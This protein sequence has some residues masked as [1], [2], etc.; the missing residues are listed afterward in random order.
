MNK[1]SLLHAHQMFE[2][3][4][5][6]T[7]TGIALVYGSEQ[8]SYQE[9]NVQANQLAHYLQRLGVGPESLV[10]VCME[11]SFEAVIG[12]LAILKAG[13][14]Y[15]SLD[16]ATPPERLAFMLEDT[17][18][19]LLLTK[20]GSLDPHLAYHGQVISLDREHPFYDQESPLNPTSSVSAQ[21]QAYVIYT[22]GSTGQPKGV[23]ITHRGLAN[24]IRWHQQAFHITP[25]DRATQVAS[26]SFD[27]SVW[28]LWPY[29]TAGASVYFPDE[30]TRVDPPR[31]QD[32]LLAHAITISFLPT[33][34]AEHILRLPWPTA[35][36]LRIL[37]TGGDKL[38]HYPSASLPFQVVNN[39]GP[40]ENSVVTTSCLLS[41]QEQDSLSPSIGCPISNTSVYVLDAQMLPVPVGESGE[42]YIGGASLARGY[43]KRPDITAERFVPDPFARD[44]G[45]CLYRSG[46]LVRYRS[47][48]HLEFMGR[49][50]FQVKIRGF[51]IEL[52]EIEALLSSHP[53]VQDAMVLASEKEDGEKQLVAY[54]IPARQAPPSL[55]ELRTFLQQRLPRYMV[56]TAFLWIEAWP[57]TVNGK[58][59][60][61]KLPAP[62]QATIQRSEV[63]QPARTPL[64]ETLVALWSE[65]MSISQVG[66]HD[67]FF[68]LGG[69]S[70][71]A[72]QI[73]ARIR[74]TLGIELS[75]LDFFQAAT[76]AAVA[77][78][79]ERSGNT[80]KRL[81]AIRP[82]VQQDDC[83]LSFAQERLWFLD[84]LAPEIA[85]YNIPIALRLTGALD[86]AALEQSLADIVSR[87]NAL[88][89]SFVQLGDAPVQHVVAS[90]QI[91]LCKIDL[92]ALPAAEVMAVARQRMVTEAH[93]PFDLSVDP[94]LRMFLLQLSEED[95]ILLLVMHH[96]I[97]DGWS[98]KV[99]FQELTQLYAS[100]VT[101]VPVSLPALPIQYTDFA[102]WQREW[103][104]GEALEQQLSYWKQQLHDSPPLLPLPI[105]RPRAE[106]QTF[107]GAVQVVTLAP[108]LAEA[109]K[110]LSRQEGV[111]LF[112]TLF[113][114][115]N[116]LLWC[117][118][119]QEDIPLGTPVANRTQIET[120]PLIGFFVNTLVL[121]T[122]LA[123]DP[124]FL[125]LL[126]QVSEVALEAYAH[127]DAPF[128]CVVEAIHPERNIGY[129]P[130][131]QVLFALQDTSHQ[132]LELPEVSVEP[133]VVE[134]K[135][136]LFD[137]SMEV[138]EV[139]TGL[140]VSMSYSTDLFDEATIVWML[141][142]YETLLSS[143][144]ANPEL[145][146]SQLPVLPGGPR[147][148]IDP[149]ERGCKPCVEEVPAQ[150][151]VTAR[152]FEA[153]RTAV[154][155]I[156]VG[157]WAD[158]LKLDHVEIHDNFFDLGG[159]S[160]L[161]TRVVSRI[162]D[163]FQV[164]LPVRAVFQANDVAELADILARHE[165]APGQV[166]ALA[167]LHQRINAMSAEDIRMALQARKK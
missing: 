121:R 120:E 101:G 167:R 118:T 33:P 112:M 77:S 16:P 125:A 36:E 104:Q 72:T 41:T 123:D 8:L 147:L 160:L 114:A 137:I 109:L 164:T 106:A 31:L 28:E 93:C 88:R 134:T 2:R 90:R 4:V 7:S 15:V 14:A 96:I 79:I 85:F 80:E 51:R 132:D 122:N 103:L 18:A 144:V 12:Q 130:L 35:T 89:I 145:R 57:L 108:Q 61:Q 23:Q 68:D 21:N 59:D 53:G 165:K 155:E 67:N 91:A 100:Y 127:Q 111:T 110:E 17:Q 13:G 64:E 11:R 9:L 156:L 1:T 99:L 166:T 38:H 40:T 146:L 43:L 149:G 76:P 58:V 97:V 154:E 39:Y 113:A 47:D 163:M 136:A 82:A 69:H 55:R 30:E 75:L 143:I 92:R 107:H 25:Q 6:E 150:Q 3:Q 139:A 34:L 135:M 84:Q 56:P 62:A 102:C 19:S 151:D 27:A 63:F 65:V 119:G 157:I 73:V 105:D 115:F 45:A 22:S 94:L 153:P 10:G 83:P 138:A 78:Q 131:F 71:L 5:E 70:L 20:R 42:L 129:N 158:V 152:S 37:L 54:L 124:S 116:A 66:I 86:I 159:H 162:R 87:H 161:V 148:T 133:L 141:K 128:E 50:D 117:A 142:H 95:Y 98:V 46:D 32:W 24:L 126:K 60:R 29:I 49:L 81:P 140:R 48:G 74:H 26:L 52:G 44:L